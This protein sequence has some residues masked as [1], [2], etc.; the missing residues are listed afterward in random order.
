[1][2]R[3]RDLITAVFLVPPEDSERLENSILQLLEHPELMTRISTA[4][5]TH[6]L[7]VHSTDGMCKNYYELMQTIL[8]SGGL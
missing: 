3:A 5:H 8:E 4:A 2:L 6:V 1:M 7:Q